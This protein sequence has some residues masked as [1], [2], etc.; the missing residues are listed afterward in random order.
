MLNYNH[1]Y[2]FHIVATEGSIARAADRLGLSQPT[3]SEQVRSLERALDVRLFDREGGRLSLTEAG[4]L[5]FEHTTVMFRAGERLVDSLCKDKT[6]IPRSLRVG[7]SSAVSR[8][9]TTDF[10][11]PLFAIDS[12]VPSIRSGD[13][14]DLLLALRDRELDLVL[15]EGEPTDAAVRGFI[16]A[17]I[18]STKLVAVAP[19]GMKRRADWQDLGLLHYR[20]SSAFRWEVD[21][22]LEKH[23]LQPR[24]VGEADDP[25]FLL[26][27]AMRGGYVAI[28]PRSIVRDALRAQRVEVIAEVDASHAGV[29]AVYQDGES[30]QLAR[31]AVEVLVSH[32]L[33]A[34]D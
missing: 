34:N 24:I 1:L 27:S 16:T 22:Y 21:S 17:L 29:H 14:A 7:L 12:C 31:R 32:A 9:T 11:M 28:V 10:L 18:D 25:T 4:R 8:T 30:A 13:S 6:Q 19:A 26:E 15:L 3:V 5:A 33:A 23:S 20:A 2:Y